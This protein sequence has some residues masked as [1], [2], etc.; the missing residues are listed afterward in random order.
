LIHGDLSLSNVVVNEKGVVYLIDWG[1]ANILPT[2][3]F[4]V[5]EVYLNT[6]LKNSFKLGYLSAFLKGLG[7]EENYI[8]RN[9]ETINDMS[10]LNLTDK[11]RWAIDND[12]KEALE[13]Y[14]IKLMKSKNQLLIV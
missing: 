5:M 9:N 7:L 8:F 14:R 6:I 1:S 12:K 2:P 4:Q 11:I 3:Q 13:N 10:L